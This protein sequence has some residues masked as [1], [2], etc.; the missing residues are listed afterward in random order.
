MLAGCTSGQQQD[1]HVRASD[2]EQ[3]R[4]CAKQKEERLAKVLDI[5]LVETSHVDAEFLGEM[6]RRLFGELLQQRLQLSIRRCECNSRLQ[7]K[8]RAVS[9][10]A[11]IGELQRDVHIGVVPGETRRQYSHNRVVLV[12]QLKCAADHPRVRI[13]VTLPKAIAEDDDRLW[14][15][16]VRRVGGQQCPA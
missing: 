2:L 6:V 11:I 12:D 15:L 7:L 16:A 9:Y 8:Q 10:V 3:Q 5:L 14:I 13:E 4:H 1:R